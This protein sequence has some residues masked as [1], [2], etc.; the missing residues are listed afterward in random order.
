MSLDELQI[1]LKGDLR[2]DPRTGNSIYPK[3]PRLALVHISCQDI[4]DW[5]LD[6][7]SV[8]LASKGK[9]VQELLID[10]AVHFVKASG[11]SRPKVFKLRRITL[12]P[13]DRRGLSGKVSFGNLTSRRHYPGRHR[14]DVLINGVVH[15]L[16]DFEVTR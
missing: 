7:Q 3:H 4:P 5:G 9:A 16:A 13:S 15:P 6:Q 10:Y 14:I 11:V 8:G 12:S 2:Q 1:W